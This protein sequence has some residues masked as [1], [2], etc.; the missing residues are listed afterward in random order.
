MLTK[1]CIP[2]GMIQS[3]SYL[4]RDE[5]SGQLALIDCGFYNKPVA[6]AIRAAGGDLRYILLTHGH[7]DH[8][9]GVARGK[10]A[11][12]AAR[13]GIGAADADY[14]RAKPPGEALDRPPF[15]RVKAMEP[16]LPLR[17][18]DEIALGESVLTVLAT[19]GHTRGGVCY[20]TAA[21]RWIF[22]GDTL[23]F[24][25]VGRDDLPGGDWPTLCRS[26][27]RLAEL[28]GDYE[29]FPGHGCAT[30]LVHERASNP[31]L[32]KLLQEGGV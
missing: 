15:N 21:E 26:L 3:N 6:E 28:E 16:D 10:E 32:T 13:V 20:L 18:G 8:I 17:D 29:I 14:L 11:Y 25:E 9:I 22:S 5:P 23:F 24:E 4:L 2:V 19:P 27:L 30:S 12:P 7:F 1:S 31:Y